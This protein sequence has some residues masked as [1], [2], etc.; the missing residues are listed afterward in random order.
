MNGNVFIANKY[1]VKS[2]PFLC[3]MKFSM[4]DVNSW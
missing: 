1:I 3:M 2:L 4:M